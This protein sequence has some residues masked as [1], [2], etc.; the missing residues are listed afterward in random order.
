MPIRGCKEAPFN[1][2][3]S[4]ISVVK[5]VIVVAHRSWKNYARVMENH[6]KMME[7]DSGKALGTLIAINSLRLHAD[8]ASAVLT[9]IRTNRQDQ[10]LV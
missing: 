3:R 10:L 1:T 7:F 2:H 6:G 4:V 8:I 9:C 5:L